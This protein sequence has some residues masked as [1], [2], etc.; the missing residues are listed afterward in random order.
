VTT[1]LRHFLAVVVPVVWAAATSIAVSPAAQTFV[2]H[3]PWV[4][5]YIPLAAGAARAAYK[6]LLGS[7][8]P[9]SAPQAPGPGSQTMAAK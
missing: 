6:A 3:H 1:H 7:S 9:V 5:V 2:T 4:A 8:E